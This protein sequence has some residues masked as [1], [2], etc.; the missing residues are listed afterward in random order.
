MRNGGLSVPEPVGIRFIPAPFGWN[1]R[2]NMM[3]EFRGAIV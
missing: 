2:A 1:P 3:N